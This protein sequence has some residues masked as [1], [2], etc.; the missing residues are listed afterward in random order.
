MKRTDRLTILIAVL[1]FLAFAAYLGSYAVRSLRGGI[2]TAD[3]IS[4]DFDRT[5]VANGIVVRDELVLT[6]TE[7]YV[8][9]NF[10][11]GEKIAAG[12]VIATAVSS[13][14]GLERANRIHTL[15][16]EISRVRSALRGLD[17]ADSLTSRETALTN[18]SR[19][20]AA[21]VVRHDVSTLDS[22]ALNLDS[23]LLG[24][25]NE[26]VSQERLEALERELQSLRTSSTEDAVTITAIAAGT[27][28]SVVDGYEN[29]RYTDVES[30][31]PG[32]LEELIR[33]GKQSFDGAFGK[34][35]LSHQW[36]YAAVMSTVDAANLTVGRTA[37]LNFG[38]YYA[39]DVSARVMS[40]S[41][42]ENGNVVVVFRCDSALSDTMGMRAVTASVIF[43]S[44]DG[45]R[46]PAQAIRTEEDS[47]TTY[48]WCVTA[49]QL[50]KKSVQIIYADHDFVIVA[51]ES[52]AK[53][54]REG[55]TVVVS[56]NDLY[57]GKVV[58]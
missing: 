6:S 44:Y 54:L 38:R 40:I 29:V 4:A 31:M 30:I 21:A 20:L 47:E 45:I 1:L 34:L 32:D 5:G 57:V 25:D 37:K 8:D 22:A 42:S 15:E 27:Y 19:D 33:S 50:E 23:L 49:M 43:G 48:V 26:L 13:D 9:V 3:A 28:S 11:D 16:L 35:V 56:G 51:R 10:A 24:V 17:S 2:V 39:S 58:E 14:Q 52:T 36:Y 53:A 18:A 41:P 46:I 55:N 12:S 7:S